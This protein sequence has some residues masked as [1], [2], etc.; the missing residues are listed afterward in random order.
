MQPGA[1]A[2]VGRF[3]EKEEVPVDYEECAIEAVDASKKTV[4]LSYQN[5]KSGPATESMAAV[6]ERAEEFL[7][8]ED[9]VDVEP[10]NNAEILRCLEFRY[11]KD[12][13]YCF[14][15][16]SLIATN[17]NKTLVNADESEDQNT[18]R[19]YALTGGKRIP[20][21]HL[22]NQTAIVF[23]QLLDS[24]KNQ[25]IC[26]SG[27]S[28][29][30]K[31]YST[32]QCLRF[33]TSIYASNDSNEEGKLAKKIMSSNPFLEGFG[34]AKTLR[35]KDSSRFG[36]YFLIYVDLKS[37]MIKGAKIENYLLEKSRVIY[38]S[39]NERNY[40]IFY[41]VMK[42]MPKADQKK[43]LLTDEER[44]A[45]M[46]EYLITNRS[47]VFEA[48][49]GK[50]LKVFTEIIEA[51]KNIEYSQAEI[52]AVWK[53]ISVVLNL[54]NVKVD[55]SLFVEGQRECGL[56]D[57]KYL[58]RC[59]KLLGL[60][61]AD[62][63]YAVCSKKIGTVQQVLTPTQCEGVKEAL[64][65]EL[66][67]NL[68]NWMVIKLN[69]KLLPKDVRGLQSVGILDIFGF[70]DFGEQN[71]L[72]QLCINYTNEKLQKLYNFCVFTAEKKIFEES[73]QR[74]LQAHRLRL[75][76]LLGQQRSR[77]RLHLE[78]PPAPL[79]Q[80]TH[81]LQQDED[82]PLPD[83]AHRKATHL[84]RARH[85]GEE[86]RR[87]RLEHLRSHV[88]RRPARLPHLQTQAARPAAGRY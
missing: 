74:H 73:R 69:V 44:P 37:K 8:R 43:F 1:P 41:A 77:S 17:P 16:P 55:T 10:L 18:F 28:G 7:M 83:P 24:G 36:K 30:G 40:H 20:K 31:S 65:K 4:S 35:N 49:P 78:H 19:K 54:A 82:A 80:Q 22:F 53:I 27:E 86:Q 47:G 45:D 51:F 71:S 75:R 58:S 5:G 29:A 67:N 66:F 87:A 81:G 14:C 72:E 50:D 12:L 9:L 52:E 63:I 59:L 48:E 84:Q 60:G 21:P 39:A 15:G 42:H 2:W 68:F 62:L 11:W 33:I 64:A 46:K 13:I 6:L 34:N 25:A 76:A 61:K 56:V 57:S 70:E 38:H 85:R 23:W 26:I 3:E 79:E 88:S 32:F